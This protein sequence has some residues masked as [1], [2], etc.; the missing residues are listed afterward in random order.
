MNTELQQKALAHQAIRSSVEYR[1]EMD[2][3]TKTVQ[4]F[5]RTLSLVISAASRWD[6]YQ[7]DYLLPRHFDDLIEAVLAAQL[8][9]ENGALKPARRELRYLLEVSVNLSIVDEVCAE[10]SL[11]ER[12]DHYRSK[13]TNKANIDHIRDLPLRLLGDNRVSFEKSVL[14]LWVKSTNYVHLTKQSMDEKIRLR[15]QGITLGFETV[16]MLH[17]TVAHVHDACS[18]SVILAFESIGPSFTGDL[19]VGAIDEVDDWSF[20]AS[21]FVAIV[22]SSFDY[23]HERKQRLEV[24]QQRRASRVRSQIPHADA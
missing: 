9:I 15:E 22:D 6:K 23:K 5:V 16:A 2:Y 4:D 19:L 3:L 1:A 21:P 11:Q 17:E 10:K 20:H 13:R 7:A 14:E 12:I 18:A 24:H 8:S